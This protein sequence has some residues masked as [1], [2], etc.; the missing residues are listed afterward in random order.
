MSVEQLLNL[1]VNDSRINELNQR[2]LKVRESIKVY[3]NEV[4]QMQARLT[5][6]I[7][8][9]KQ[10]EVK[11]RGVE[12][13]VQSA[14]EELKR[15]DQQK[16]QVSSQKMLD[17]VNLKIESQRLTIDAL[18]ERWLDAQ[19]NVE[20]ARDNVEQAE[21]QLKEL[22]GNK[23]EVIS[24]GNVELDELETECRQLLDLR[25]TYLDG[26]ET[27]VLQ[28]YEKQR[29]RDIFAIVVFDITSNNC[30]RCGMQIPNRTFEMVRYNGEVTSCSSCASLLFYSGS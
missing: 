17:G 30:P 7:E 21:K 16:M 28:A 18:E 23:E 26:L 12:F 13:E 27:T 8:K 20:S 1:S 2:I 6:Y 22:E 14:E 4:Q 19:E 25:P 9:E 3:V 10:L 24:K 15:L 5:G 11:A 29:A